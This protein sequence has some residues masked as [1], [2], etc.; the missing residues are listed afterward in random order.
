M[1]QHNPD[2]LI[3]GGGIA[4]FA[5][6]IGASEENRQVIIIDKNTQLG[7]NATQS[8]VGTICGAYYPSTTGSLHPVGYRFMREFMARVC[9][10]SKTN[11]RIMENRLSVIPY[12]WSVLQKIVYEELANRHVTCL[13]GSDLI[14]A[15]VDGNKI[16]RVIVSVDNESIAINPGATVDCSGNGAISV[17]LG[18][19]MIRDDVYQ[20]ASQLFRVEN[21]ICPGEYQLELAI[22]RATLRLIHESRGKVSPSAIS[23]VPGS[24]RHG[25]V[26][27]KLTLPDRIT[28]DPAS[29]DQARIHA[30]ESIGQLFPTLKKNV[31]YL[32][33]ASVEFIF[34]QLGVRVNERS[35][36]KYVLTESD[37]LTGR[38]FEDAIAIGTWPMEEWGYDGKVTMKFTENDNGYDIPVGCLRSASLDNLYF[39]GKNISASTKAIASARVMGTCLQTGYAAGKI[40]SH[41]SAEGHS[42]MTSILT[43][44]LSE[45]RI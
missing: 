7:G 25:H 15:D 39:G 40:A 37:V 30:L 32:A 21:V 31:D 2:I 5:A 28:D 36:G 45:T 20:A 4:G 6:A 33:S 42:K 3:V 38:K 12:E 23:L 16:T 13:T 26:D 8:N 27:L 1:K 9:E 14:S 22:K 10:E 24:L 29:H 17:L 35:R 43:L 34:P 11:P 44:E 18:L 19:E 41:P